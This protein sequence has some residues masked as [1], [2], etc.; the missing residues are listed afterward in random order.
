MDGTKRDAMDEILATKEALVPSSGFVA[1]VMEQVREEAV[2]PKPIPFPWRRAVVGMVLA[3]GVFAWF[4]V[5]LTRM[6]MHAVRTGTA[7]SVGIPE[8]AIG[9]L[10]QWDWVGIAVGVTL[11]SWVLARRLAGSDG[12]I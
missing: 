8:V 2:A 9:A 10:G 11:T 7:V 3:L 4:G 6:I 5:E 1:R 12:L